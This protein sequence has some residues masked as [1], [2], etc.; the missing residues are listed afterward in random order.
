MH[1]YTYIYIYIYIYK[2][3][4]K[5]IQYI[6]NNNYITVLTTLSLTGMEY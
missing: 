5:F 2:K 3:Y 6:L 4:V 1:P